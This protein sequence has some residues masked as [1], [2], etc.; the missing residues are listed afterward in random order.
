MHAAAS[1]WETS[2]ETL[3]TRDAR[4]WHPDGRSASYGELASIAADIEPPTGPLP[5]K[6]RAQFKLIGQPTRVWMPREIVTGR[7]QFG[8]DAYARRPHGEV[9]VR[10]PYFDGDVERVDDAAARRAPVRDVIVIKGPGAGAP[11]TRHLAE[12]VAVLADNTWSCVA[13]TRSARD[14]VAAGPGARFIRPP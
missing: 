12:G 14:H 5:L 4:V 1:G 10:C 2:A 8:I 7:A 6:D 3:S 11:F 13:R 9:M